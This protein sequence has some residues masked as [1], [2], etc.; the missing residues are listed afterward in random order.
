MLALV[1]RLLQLALKFGRV[2]VRR[3][4]A[5]RPLLVA[6]FDVALHIVGLALKVGCIISVRHGAQ[7]WAAP[8]KQ[9]CCKHELLAVKLANVLHPRLEHGGTVGARNGLQRG[10][11]LDELVLRNARAHELEL[12]N[13]TG[14]HGAIA[15]LTSA[16]LESY[17]PWWKR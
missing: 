1:A 5:L 10:A 16:T 12:H 13:V 17:A 2:L 6:H 9:T 8:R 3:L 15:N 7:S 11:H 14:G 4:Q